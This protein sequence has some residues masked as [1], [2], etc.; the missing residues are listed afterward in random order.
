MTERLEESLKVLG[1]ARIHAFLDEIS[2]AIGPPV[3]KFCSVSLSVLPEGPAVDFTD[4][5]SA[6]VF[7]G[8][9]ALK[10]E[11]TFL[12]NLAHESVHLH[13][14]TS[15]YASGLEEGFA[16]DF[17]LTKV[18]EEFGPQERE[19][20]LSHL[21]RTYLQ[22]LED[23]HRLVAIRPDATIDLRNIRGRLTGFS[24]IQ[25]FLAF[26]ELGL[27]RSFRLAQCRRMR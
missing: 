7:L 6:T 10:Y 27:R 9:N 12:A 13:Q 3:R 17:E 14:A 1:E 18:F 2:A 4:D 20:F 21:P 15:G 23:Y 19:Y 24:F 22:A 11:P 5:G 26:P 25:V 16:T 8:P